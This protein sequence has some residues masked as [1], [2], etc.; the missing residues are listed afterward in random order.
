MN[1][2]ITR[3]LSAA[4]QASYKLA[5]LSAAARNKLLRDVAALIQ[6]NQKR[7]LAANA[8]DVRAFLGEQSV[9]DRLTLTAKKISGIVSAIHQV[10]ALPDPLTRV[11]ETRNRPNGLRIQKISV[12]LGVVGVIYESRPNVTADLAVLALKTGNAVALKGGKEA[13]HSN[14]II[15]SMFHR[16]LKKH[17]LPQDAV[18]LIDPKSDWKTSLLGARGL[19]DVLIPRGSNNLIQWVRQNS[20]LPVIET[21]AGVCHVFADD[22]NVKKSVEIIVN[23]KTTAPAVCNSLDTLVVTRQMS[24]GLLPALAASLAEW[25]VE[26]FAD[27]AAYRELKNIYPADLLRPARLEHFGL[28]FLSLKMSIKTVK[29]FTEGLEFVKGHT[30][31]HSEAILTDSQKHASMFLRQVDAAAVYHN[32]STRF[33]DGAEFGM[34][35]EVGIS[36]QKLHARGPMGLEALTSYK[37]V[38]L[39]QGQIRR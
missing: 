16:A 3:H 23:A 25:R 26:I 20:R 14:K 27:S 18:L 7:I 2:E 29:T 11:L 39:G 21:G 38:V 28:E 12:P 8:R 35:A 30:S 13:Y 32:A 4:K 31:G 1:T 17:R 22:Y 15:V 36:T 9:R 34:G 5:E 37:W 24:K 19:V 33:T 6:Q 10:A